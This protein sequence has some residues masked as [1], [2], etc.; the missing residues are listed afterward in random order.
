MRL[1]WL[2][3]LSLSFPVTHI[4]LSHGAIRRWLVKTLGLWPF[5]GLYSLVS[6]ATL[7]G[8]IWASRGAELGP[9]LW[10]LPHT[11]GLGISVPLMLLAFVLLLSIPVSPSPAGMMPVRPE[12][13]GILRVTRHP[14]N[15]AFAAWGLAHVATS[16]HAGDVA[17]FGAFALLG[18]FGAYHLDRRL[19]AE[20]GEA[21]R[22]FAAETSVLPFAAI[23]GGRNRLVLG[24]LKLPVLAVAVALFA[25]TLWFHGR[26]FGIPLL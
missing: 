2:I 8:A 5:R 23:L 24:E 11:V 26:L 3:L 12:A 19:L 10:E 16:G 7:G 6:F 17:F 1:T 21:F 15:M 25:A 18:V 20:R 9:R 13:R 14:M 4:V 22:V